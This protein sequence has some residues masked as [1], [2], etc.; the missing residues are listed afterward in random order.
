MMK[1]LA[2]AAAATLALAPAAAGAGDAPAPVKV[3]GAVVALTEASCIGV[4]T[5]GQT[6]EI[7]GAKPRPSVG[8][9]IVLTGTPSNAMTICMEGTHLAAVTWTKVTSCPVSRPTGY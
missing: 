2:A 3:C 1:S 4:R 5:G 8:D 6:Y 7:S 9:V